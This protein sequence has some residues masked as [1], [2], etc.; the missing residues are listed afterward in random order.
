LV[1]LNCFEMITGIIVILI[2]AVFSFAWIDSL[3]KKYPIIDAGLLKKMFFFHLLMFLAYYGYVSF[4]PS[5]SKWYYQKVVIDFRGDSWFDFYGTSTTF[6]EFVGYPF[7]KYLGFSYEAIMALFSQLG[8]MGFVYFYIFF[9]E[10]VRFK[11]T[12]LGIDLIT[13]LF[14][15]PNLHFW[16]TSFGKGSIILLGMGLYF[17]GISRIRNR[18]P[19]IIIGAIIIYHVRPHIMLVVL[20]SSAIGFVFSSKGVS[21]T[22]RIAFL[23][24]ALGAFFFIYRDVMRLVGID[25]DAPVRQGL[26]LT[27]RATELSKAT[28]G[29]DITSYGLPMQMFTFIYRPLFI[30]AP[31]ALG[32][33]VSFENVLY[34]VLSIMVFRRLRGWKFLFT[35]N[36]LVKSA[37]L[38]FFTVS[39]ALAQISGN[40]GLA[41]RQKSQVMLLFMFVIVS[42]LD[43]EKIQ[44]F[45]RQQLQWM[46]AQRRLKAQ[47]EAQQQS[48]SV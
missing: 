47:Q 39:I 31:G 20:I 27:H 32:M 40:L 36:F 9:K 14:F 45:R 38:S 17:F 3:K 2:T 15:L 28:S 34:L 42:F 22:W 18:I 10:N 4:N 13:L 48:P 8:F 35:G 19:E 44:A 11:H 46:K 24:G 29:V 7:I 5:D 41:I 30:D 33:F 16:A 6:I 37:F 25:E 12:L 26:T 1:T 43:Q 23:I 21:P